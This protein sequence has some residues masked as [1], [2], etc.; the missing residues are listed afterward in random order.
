MQYLRHR[1]G[2][3]LGAFVEHMWSL[4][5]APAHARERILPSGTLEL[6]INLVEDEVR[7]YASADA[8]KPACHAGCVV[9]GAYDRPF[10]IDT[11][12][13]ASIVGVH[14]RQGGAAPFLSV[15][16][17]QLA[18][19]HVAL[20][21][22]WSAT[23]VARLRERLCAAPT[24]AARFQLLE[25]ALMNRMTRPRDSHQLVRAALVRMQPALAP[26]NEVVTELGVSHRHFIELFAREVGLTP[27]TYLRVQR[28][29]RLLALT[30]R[31]RSPQW[32]RLAQLCGYFDQAHLIRDFHAFAATTPSR[33]L[34]ERS[35]TVKDNHLALTT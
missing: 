32:S 25:A 29:Q 5:D 7:V 33:Y 22:L 9:S 27:K 20:A 18:S 6:V 21:D 15:R 26:V 8:S 13:H 11:R 17:D 3:P 31:S 28:F 1:P 30:A 2:P 34:R 10:V 14:F 23:E 35:T 12:E 19:A 16:A 24:S 4:S